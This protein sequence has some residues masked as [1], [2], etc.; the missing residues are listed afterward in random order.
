MHGDEIIN[1]PSKLVTFF[2]STGTLTRNKI[3]PKKVRNKSKADPKQI[4]ADIEN[5]FP[6]EDLDL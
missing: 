2:C 6:S 3:K 5:L 4:E 1:N